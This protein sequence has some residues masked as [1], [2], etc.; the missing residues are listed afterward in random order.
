M[1]I[2]YT[3]DVSTSSFTSFTKLLFRWRG[4]IWKSV[5]KELILWLVFYFGLS[6]VYRLFLNKEQRAIFEDVVAFCLKYTDFIPLTFMLGFFITL[7]ITRWWDM[8]RNIGWIDNISLYI[9][10]YI[11]GKS[12]RARMIRRNILRYAVLIQAL[13]YRDISIK[14]RRRFPTME[15]L[16]AAGFMSVKEMEALDSIVSPHR[17]YWVPAHWAMTAI[18]RARQEGF[19]KSDHAVQDL[20]ERVRSYRSSLALLL[21]YDW[22]PIPLVYTQMVVLIVRCYFLLAL[23]A[24]QYVTSDTRELKT[25]SPIDLYF[26]IVSTIQ[27]TFYIG[28][29][30]VAE[31]LLNPMGDDD[32]DFEV[33]WILDRN[34]Q[35]GLSVVDDAVGKEPPMER[36]MF[37]EDSQPEPLY[38]SDTACAPNNPQLGSAAENESNSDVVKMVSRPSEKNI[39]YDGVSVRS[40]QPPVF[41]RSTSHTSSTRS[42]GL[43]TRLNC[44]PVL[45]VRRKFRQR[46]NSQMVKETPHE[47]YIENAHGIAN[48]VPFVACDGVSIGSSIGSYDVIEAVDR[49][50]KAE[51]L[52][53][54]GNGNKVEPIKKAEKPEI[55][56][57]PPQTQEIPADKWYLAVP[58]KNDDELSDVIEEEDEVSQKNDKN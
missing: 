26:P 44:S 41:V 13:I 43:F 4:S 19:I 46:H 34:L 21:V 53:E 45:A 2:T 24:R 3:L 29:L 8:M 50:P 37:W 32:D 28:W 54:K 42:N 15:T 36:D 40:V 48:P 20:L 38:S 5:Y 35:M 18:L 39:Q 6:C 27:F 58:H 55:S 23:M 7:V 56:W 25:A 31:A 22:V 47:F 49:L 52:I 1:T 12:E 16:Q 17:K 14:V 10:T 33:N 51:N 9:A 30:K 11:Q 57:Q